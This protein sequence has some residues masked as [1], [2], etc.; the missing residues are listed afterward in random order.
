[1]IHRA[2]DQGD[3]LLFLTGEQEIEDV[4]QEIKRKVDDLVYQDPDSVGPVV[5]IPFYSSL[6]PEKQQRIFDSSPSQRT[7]GGPPGRKVVVT[8]NIRGV[9]DGRC[10]ICCRPRFLYAEGVQS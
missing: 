4:C 2:E 5:C 9:D 7:K 6:L 10:C 1:M 8:S 3:I